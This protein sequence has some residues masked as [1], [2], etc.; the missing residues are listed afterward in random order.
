MELA[1]YF[2]GLGY[3]R[4][5][6]QKFGPRGDFITAP[7]ISPLFSICMAYQCAEIL[8]YSA[9]VTSLNLAQVRELWRRLFCKLCK[10]IKNYRGIIIC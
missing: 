3:Y 7:E 4:N 8:D 6:L 5:G 10:K 2:P 9:V 1:L